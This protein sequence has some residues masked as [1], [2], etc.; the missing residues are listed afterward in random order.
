MQ[1]FSIGNCQPFKNIVI[2]LKYFTYMKISTSFYGFLLILLV[3]GCKKDATQPDTDGTFLSAHKNNTEFWISHQPYASLSKSDKTIWIGGYKTIENTN[4]NSS[5]SL[6][7][8]LAVIDLSNLKKTTIKDVQ[9]LYIFGGDV[10]TDRY[11]IDTTNSDNEIEIT[12]IDETK[13]IMKGKFSLNLIRDKW[14]STNGEETTFKE[15]EFIAN[16]TEE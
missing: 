12:E 3:A 2:I 13:K 10:V 9:Y 4:G 8:Q 7:L 14:F 6:I 1:R 15:G 11:S 5:E 16:Y